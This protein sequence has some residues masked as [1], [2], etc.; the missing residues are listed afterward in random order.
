MTRYPQSWPHRLAM[1]A[2]DLLASCKQ[3]VVAVGQQEG[4]DAELIGRP[5]KRLYQANGLVDFA[6]RELRRAAWFGRNNPVI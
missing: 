1:R 4:G 5:A 3:K 2:V 6:E